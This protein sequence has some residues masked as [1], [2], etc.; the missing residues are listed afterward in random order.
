[1]KDVIVNITSPVGDEYRVRLSSSN[2]RF[3]SEKVIQEIDGCIN[4]LAIELE[5]AKGQMPTGHAVLSQIEKVVADVFLRH[6]DAVICFICDF[7]SPIPATKKKIPPQ[8]YRS[9]LFTKMFEYYV[10]HHSVGN[11]VQSVLTISGIDEDYYIHIIARSEHM[12]YVHLISED[13]RTGYSK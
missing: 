13:I 4:I 1:M 12:K 9:L 11:V 2:N 3:L 10:S 7:L 6:S 5:R 8:Q